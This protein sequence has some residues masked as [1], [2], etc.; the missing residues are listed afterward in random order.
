MRP[1]TITVTSG[2][3]YVPV[4]YRGGEIGVT[5]TPAGSGNYDVAYTHES[6]ADGADAV[7]RWVDVEDMSAATT[8]V[9]KAVK[10]ATCLR[11]TL[12]SGTSVTVDIT[13]S[14]I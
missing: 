6:I 1:K 2:E 7:T 13:Q 11:V 14:D 3:S 10:P 4:N 9:S 8:V 12:N 5:A